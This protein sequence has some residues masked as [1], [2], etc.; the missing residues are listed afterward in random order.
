MAEQSLPSLKGREAPEEDA[1]TR[2][3]MREDLKGQPPPDGGGR[4]RESRRKFRD[5]FGSKGEREGKR[6]ERRRRRGRRNSQDSRPSSVD[7]HS[8]ITLPPEAIP[9]SD[10]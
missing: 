5:A 2:G 9:I 8:H 6:R 10:P 7:K 3:A 1:R 4:N